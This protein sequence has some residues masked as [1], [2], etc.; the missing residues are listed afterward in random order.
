[1]HL[2]AEKV[3]LP[4]PPKNRRV[5]FKLEEIRKML[6]NS[7]NLRFKAGVLLAVSSGLRAEEL[8]S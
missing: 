3:K 4:K 7:E 8:Y 5:I 1:M 6:E 2:F